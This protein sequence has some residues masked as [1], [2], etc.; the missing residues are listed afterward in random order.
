MRL[1]QAQAE[2][3]TVAHFRKEESASG[4]KGYFN[5]SLYV[6]ITAVTCVIVHPI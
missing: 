1:I 2:R 3:R 6:A 5:L 4:G